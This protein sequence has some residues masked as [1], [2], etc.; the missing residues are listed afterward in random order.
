MHWYRFYPLF[1]IVMFSGC[2][3][4]GPHIAVFQGNYAFGRGDFQA[5]TVSYL[6]A[7]TADEHT[8]AIQYNLGNVY[9]A[10]GERDAAQDAWGEALGG[11]NQEVLFRAYFNRGVLMYET[12]NYLESYQAFRDA[13]RIRPQSADAKLNLELA[14][15]S[16]S[17]GDSGRR[18]R[19]EQDD[20]PELS[21][22]NRRIMEFVRR[23]EVQSWEN[24]R[25]T[26]E[27]DIAD[28]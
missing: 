27:P 11:S 8:S 2:A 25:Q 5:A 15:E 23:R 4:G 21:A 9:H 18:A 24:E 19:D 7:L 1:V 3:F 13:V 16:I 22:E 20:R 17:T 12:A 6:S 14:Y 10:L 28:W 26:S